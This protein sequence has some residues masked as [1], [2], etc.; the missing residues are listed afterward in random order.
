MSAESRYRHGNGKS[1]DRPAQTVSRPGFP[2]RLE[3]QQ[4]VTISRER[5]TTSKSVDIQENISVSI[6][7]RS[8]IKEFLPN[9]LYVPVTWFSPPKRDDPS[10]SIDITAPKL[11]VPPPGNRPDS[12]LSSDRWRGSSFNRHVI[13]TSPRKTDSPKKVTRPFVSTLYRQTV[14]VDRLWDCSDSSDFSDDLLNTAGRQRGAPAGSCKRQEPLAA[15]GLRK[16]LQHE[17]DRAK[18]SRVYQC[19][20]AGGSVTPRELDEAHRIAKGFLG[21][22]N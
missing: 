16:R 19:L 20:E 10:R 4:S 3:F 14:S 13:G 6:P 1:V 17:I 12:G 21:R 7:S 9:P 18:M 8:T 2:L 5:D 11:V 22:N 15:S